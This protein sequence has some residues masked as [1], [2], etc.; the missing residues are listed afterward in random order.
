MS[1]KTVSVYCPPFDRWPNRIDGL[2]ELV[3]VEVAVKRG[4]NLELG[5]ELARVQQGEDSSPWPIKLA[6][7]QGSV[8]ELL[9]SPGQIIRPK[10]RL[11]KLLVDEASLRQ[12]STQRSLL[13]A[14]GN[15]S[16]LINSLAKKESQLRRELSLDENEKVPDHRFSKEELEAFRRFEQHTQ[17]F[18]ERY[19]VASQDYASG[20]PLL[21]R[22]DP[23]SRDEI[24]AELP[25]Q[26]AADWNRGSVL[27][28]WEERKDDKLKNG[29]RTFR[30]FYR[31]R[32]EFNLRSVIK[33]HF[34]KYRKHEI[35]NEELIQSR[36]INP[37][38]N[39]SFT[40]EEEFSSVLELLGEIEGSLVGWV[41]MTMKTVGEKMAAKLW[42]WME[43][44]KS[45]KSISE[46]V[47]VVVAEGLYQTEV[48]ADRDRRR[49][50]EKVIVMLGRN[51]EFLRKFMAP[52]N[53]DVLSVMSAGINYVL[54]KNG[55][56]NI[57]MELIRNSLEREYGAE[58]TVE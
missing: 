9:I 19:L 1:Q 23:Q 26:I 17:W 50:L 15:W 28:A 13:G 12:I 8:E 53:N 10:D 21:S 4:Q 45:G 7:F 46:Q 20:H 37:A 36:E 5:Q 58:A 25:H 47:K 56:L 32:V 33:K 27:V 39:D 2:E 40:S 57:S 55:Y 11:L 30:Q 51:L 54:E 6:G 38:D 16:L 24:L 49:K 34:G 48:A 3:V 43:L 41:N 14:A 52:D 18:L 42:R 31:K 35:L 44:S 22:I 29:P